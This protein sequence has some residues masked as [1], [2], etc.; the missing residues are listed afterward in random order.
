MAL[1]KEDKAVEKYTLYAAQFGKTEPLSPDLF[2][3]KMTSQIILSPTT[4]AI[5]SIKEAALEK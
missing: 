3:K 4:G 1:Y 2:G 5:E